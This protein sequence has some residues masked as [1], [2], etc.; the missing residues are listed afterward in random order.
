MVTVDR[1]RTHTGGDVEAIGLMLKR[2][3]IL[4]NMVRKARKKSGPAGYVIYDGPSKYDN[5]DIV[6]IATMKTKNTK[7]GKMIQT[8]ILRKDVE[9]HIAVKT[10]Q[11]STVCGV[12]P[13][14]P[15]AYK[16]N[17]LKKPCY[18][19]SY[20]AP[21]SVYR[22]WKR[23]GYPTIKPANFRKLLQGESIRLGSYGDPAS[24]PFNIWESIGIG[25][26]EFKH[27][28]Y[29]H[30]YLLPNFDPRALDITMI[31]LDPTT[32]QV[33]D[34]LTGRTF[35]VITDTAQVLPTEILCP[36]SEQGGRKTTCADC[37]LCAGLTRTAKNIAIVIH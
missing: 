34:G 36:A 10:G 12:C 35:R 29:T 7:T 3:T 4:E 11:D 28:G 19:I 14:R 31:S 5:V 21:L 18:V 37:G 16:A 20:K 2:H 23:G 24:V 32:P 6:V 30:G 17:K 26:G 22:R 25:S 8:W 27:T 33:P 1:V 9:P 15:L 13:L